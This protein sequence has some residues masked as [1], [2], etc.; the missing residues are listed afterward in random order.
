MPCI[1]GNSHGLK[2]II[3]SDNKRNAAS[4]NS[5]ELIHT[6]YFT[7]GMNSKFVVAKKFDGSLRRAKVE[8]RMRRVL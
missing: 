5:T 4:V 8:V 2:V 1:L 7:L 6:C 3:H